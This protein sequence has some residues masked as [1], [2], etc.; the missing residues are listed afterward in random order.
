M[1]KYLSSQS[2]TEYV[3]PQT[4]KAQVFSKQNSQNTS[5]LRHA[6]VNTSERWLFVMPTSMCGDLKWDMHGH[7]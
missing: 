2:V 1:Y 3:K 7:I 4:P 5:T 6:V